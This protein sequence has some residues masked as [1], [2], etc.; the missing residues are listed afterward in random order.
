MVAD[1]YMQGGDVLHQPDAKSEMYTPLLNANVS[2]EGEERIT[3]E[4][5]STEV[6]TLKA[7]PDETYTALVTANNRNYIQEVAIGGSKGGSLRQEMKLSYY[8]EGPR[9]TNVR[10]FDYDGTVQNGDVI[11]LENETD[12]CI[13]GATVEAAGQEVTDVLFQLKS[14]DGTPKGEAV[15]G[16]HNGYR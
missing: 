14:A 3:R 15:A 2:L 5:G 6:F 1:V 16:E 8:Y 7:R 4:D 13:L 9:V 10:Y 12:G 11:Y